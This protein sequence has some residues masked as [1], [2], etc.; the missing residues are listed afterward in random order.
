MVTA[1]PTCPRCGSENVKPGIGHVLPSC[2]S[3]GLAWDTMGDD[4]GDE[5]L[6]AGDV[7]AEIRQDDLAGDPWG[8]AVSHAMGLCEALTYVGRRDGDDRFEEAIPAEV[9]YVCGPM[10]PAV[11]RDPSCYPDQIYVEML[12]RETLSPEVANYVLRVL[13]RYMSFAKLAGRDY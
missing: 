11:A 8:T 13:D 10:G 1:A 6:T 3:C 7:L 12:D 4:T 9:R 2:Y 5:I